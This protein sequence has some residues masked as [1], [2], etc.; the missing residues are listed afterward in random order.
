MIKKFRLGKITNEG[1]LYSTTVNLGQ[2][3]G[4]QIEDY[5]KERE[6]RDSIKDEISKISKIVETH[7]N[8]EKKN[9]LAYYYKI[10][11]NLKFLD[12]QLFKNVELWSVFRLIYTLLPSIFPYISDTELATKHIA[13]TYYLGKVDENDLPKATWW[14]WYEL[15]K[16]PKLFTAKKQYKKV[17]RLIK[18]KR[19][20]VRSLVHGILEA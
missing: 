7:K 8:K 4:V 11:K 17:L 16:F 12:K 9:N 1:Y 6:I 19:C 20:S 14:Q 2:N 13:I 3:L 18:K 10:G 5:I 15:V